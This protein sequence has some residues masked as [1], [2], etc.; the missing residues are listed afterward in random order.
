MPSLALD[1]AVAGLILLALNAY[2]IDLFGAPIAPALILAATVVELLV[3]ARLRG[4]RW[5]RADRAEAFGLGVV[6]GGVFVFFVLPSLPTLYPPSSSVDAVHHFLLAN[7][8]VEQR[9]LPHDVVALSPYLG[10]MAVYPPGLALIVAV[11]AQALGQ[12]PLV[13]LHP[14]LALARA[15]SAGYVFL[16]AYRALPGSRGRLMTALCAPVLLFVPATYWVGSL[17]GEQYYAAM[18]LGEM[19]VVAG[20]LSSGGWA[21]PLLASLGLVLVYPSWLPLLAA[22]ALA[23]TARGRDARRRVVA[24]I[25]FLAPVAALLA[26]FAPGRLQAGASVLSWE[27]GAAQP[28]L[29]GPAWGL[30]ALAA[31]GLIVAL[32]T[33]G[34]P[35]A[36]LL[37]LG[38]CVAYSTAL[39]VC[40]DVC[41]ILAHYH[42][43]KSL[44][45]LAYPSAV[46]AALGI[47][48]VLAATPLGR[49]TIAAAVSAVFVAAVAAAAV[50]QAPSIRPVQVIDPDV[51]AVARWAE[52]NVDPAQV[53]YRTR[54]GIGAY[55][56]HVALLGNK[57]ESFI[58]DSFIELLPMTVDEWRHGGDWPT[59]LLMEN[60]AEAEAGEEETPLLH[61]QGSAGLLARP[62]PRQEPP[63]IERR[64]DAVLG[65][66]IHVA[67]F[68]SSG[69]SLTPGR[70]RQITL[71]W[72]VER[73]PRRPQPLVLYAH[74]LDGERRV[75]AQADQE[76]L[77]GRYASLRWPIGVVNSE[78][79]VLNVPSDAPAGRYDVQFGLYEA[80]AGSDLPVRVLGQAVERLALGPFKAPRPQLREQP[81]TPL[82]A[83]FGNR[84]GLLGYDLARTTWRA[85]ETVP[86]RLHWQALAPM[87]E[88]YTVFVHLAGHDGRP[89]AQ[90]DAQ[91]A[92]P[93]YPTSIWDEGE[94]V[95][96]D[97]PIGA[98]AD[99]PAGAYQLRV[100]LYRWDTLA[101]LPVDG[102]G[103]F[104]HLQTI[105]V[106]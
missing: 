82:R 24:V 14:I 81:A 55:W 63:Q 41:H 78:T 53:G 61:R 2:L 49:Q 1:A 92:G 27:G 10:E 99:L 13:I 96:G 70:E 88:D 71:H 67:G 101:R 102:G 105:T 56:L 5:R 69:M 98:P 46:L 30:L 57:R 77:G 42:F 28:A 32:R 25:R 40:A 52:A 90:C 22:A 26:L 7:Y 15:L 59:Y 91:P 72:Y 34:K 38:A 80:G 16:A 97:C 9:G 68:S 47:G 104:I 36:L 103:E 39:W 48:A 66:M 44:S 76:V 17:M 50:A 75:W 23:L 58:T 51:V 12:S 19:L 83:A 64:V 29:H 84:V 94:L 45:V 73:W 65:G 37:L 87:E 20:L 43:L 54:Y 33:R 21:M 31:G 95:S 74:L 8:V 4:V 85:G 86:L 93:A 106:R 89:W 11:A 3:V 100:G 18:A 60:L 6:L 79:F 35:W 62:A